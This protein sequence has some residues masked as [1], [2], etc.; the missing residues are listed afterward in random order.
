M[1]FTYKATTKDGKTITGTAEAA[2]KAS[3]CWPV[4]TKQGSIRSHQSQV[5]ATARLGSLVSSQRKKIKLNDLVIF[6]RQLSTM[7][8]AGVPL[9]RR[10]LP[11]RATPR[12]PYMREVISRYYQRC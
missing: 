6:T 5:R 8:S 11:C 2:N 3:A 1:K 7:I 4:C 10:C 9:A 12:S